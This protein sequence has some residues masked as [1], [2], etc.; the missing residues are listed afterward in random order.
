MHDAARLREIADWAATHDVWIISDDIY[1]AFDFT[2]THRS[3]LAVSP[4]QRERVVIIGSV[5]KEHAMTGWRVGWL[6]APEP[7]IAGAR[8]HIAQTITHVPN[9]TQHAALAALHDANAPRIAAETYQRRRDQLAT[10]LAD[11]EGIHAPPP[12]GGMFIFADVRSLL[13]KRGFAS[14]AELANWLLDTAHVAVVPG[15]AF[16][17]PGHL[18]LCFAVDDETLDTAIERLTSALGAAPN[19]NIEQEGDNL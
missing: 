6:A 3:I 7:V 17:S 16:E 12:D 13:E 19:I 14:S 11:V 1:C 4:E 15:E 5:S 2:S 8:R 18:R 10:A 9:I